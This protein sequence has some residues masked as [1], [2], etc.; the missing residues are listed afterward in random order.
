M[1]CEKFIAESFAL[2]TAIRLLHLSSQS[3]AEHVALGEFYDGQAGFID[4][5]AEVYQGLTRRVA[6]W[7]DTRLPKGRP[8]E[9]LEDYLLLIEAE[10]KGD[11]QFESL[12]SILAE[13][14]TLTARTLYKLRNLK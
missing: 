8:I 10:L 1:S 5:Y 7:P 3:Y 13:I 14:E 12:K 4:E 11:D 6:S 2:G 9:L